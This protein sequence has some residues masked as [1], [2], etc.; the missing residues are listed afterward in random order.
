MATAPTAPAPTSALADGLSIVKFLIKSE[1]Q[2]RWRRN[3]GFFQLL[4][5]AG[6][7]FL[8]LHTNHSFNFVLAGGWFVGGVINLWISMWPNKRRNT[9]VLSDGILFQQYNLGILPWRFVHSCEKWHG[10]Q[11][12]RLSIDPR[13]YD[14]VQRRPMNLFR[15]TKFNIDIRDMTFADRDSLLAYC[16]M[17]IAEANGGHD[18]G[19]ESDRTQS[20][21]SFISPT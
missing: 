16:N 19:P 3:I 9:L 15:R 17:R 8:A 20:A 18:D 2:S 1:K 14:V 13:A 12:L 10:G 6:Y 11:T 21:D 4:L 5:S 7:L